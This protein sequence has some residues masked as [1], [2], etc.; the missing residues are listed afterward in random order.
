MAFVDVKGKT[1]IVTGAGAGINF[2]FAQL[3]LSSGCNVLIADL[4]LRPES[5]D[6]IN[7]YSNQSPRARFQRTDVTSWDQLTAMFDTC[8]KEFGSADIICPGAGVYEPVQTTP[9]CV[10]VNLLTLIF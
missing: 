10:P 3:L 9:S 1:A 4:A 2:C 7:K 8:E 6:L 5:E